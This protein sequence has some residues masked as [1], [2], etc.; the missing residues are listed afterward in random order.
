M[1]FKYFNVCF[2]MILNIFIIAIIGCPILN[3]MLDYNVCRCVHN[4]QMCVGQ[5]GLLNG[6]VCRTDGFLAD[7]GP[8]V[9][10]CSH[11]LGIWI[12][13][14]LISSVKKVS[15]RHINN[16]DKLHKSYNTLYFDFVLV[17]RRAIL[18]R[19]KLYIGWWCDSCNYC[20]GSRGHA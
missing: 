19:M 15:H 14:S 17:K 6:K 10:R 7:L 4:S 2:T 18:R 11:T 16:V 5:S 3:C 8:S 1:I 20:W 13:L 12:S 9:P